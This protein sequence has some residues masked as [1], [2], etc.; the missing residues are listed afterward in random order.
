[1]N[2]ETSNELIMKYFDG[3]INDIEEVQLMQH[4]KSCKTCSEEF[5]CMKETFSALETSDEINPPEDFEA[6]VM[7]RI[8][9]IE[10]SEKLK[11]SRFLVLLYNVASI[12]SIVLL[13][14]YVAD[15]RQVDIFAIAG[16]AQEYLGSFSNAASAVFGIARDIFGLVGSIFNSLFEICFTIVKAYYYVIIAMLALLAAIQRLLVVFTPQDGRKPV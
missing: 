9:A 2:C 4:I 6:R 16:R 10:Y 12:V 7:D 13:L 11:Y 1:M 15:I 3:E 14:F 5:V 8:N